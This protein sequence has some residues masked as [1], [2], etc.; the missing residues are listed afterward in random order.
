MGLLD[1]KNICGYRFTWFSQALQSSIHSQS[2]MWSWS[3]CSRRSVVH[4]GAAGRGQVR[5]PQA[6]S[7]RHLS[8]TTVFCIDSPQKHKS[9]SRSLYTEPRKDTETFAFTITG[10]CEPWCL[11]AG[12]LP[13][14]GWITE[15]C[16]LFYI[17]NSKLPVSV[18]TH[19]RCLSVKHHFLH[20]FHES[21]HNV[22]T[23]CGIQLTFFSAMAF[24]KKS[25]SQL[26]SGVSFILRDYQGL[27]RVQ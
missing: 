17:S 8:E 3:F 4:P 11:D 13:I 12:D 25:R 26:D 16:S 9:M 24:S 14:I 27:V 21:V 2:Q 1:R 15:K 23:Q 19:Y 7:P 6:H 5:L 10:L 20:Q 22:D 18:Q